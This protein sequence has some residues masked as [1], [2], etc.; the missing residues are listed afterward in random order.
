[1]CVSVLLCRAVRDSFSELFLT[2]SYELF[3]STAL[4]Y[5]TFG[6][7]TESRKKQLILGDAPVV[8]FSVEQFISF[9]FSLCSQV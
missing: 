5:V 9:F 1:M 7:F 4:F 3:I 8:I 2:N 6:L